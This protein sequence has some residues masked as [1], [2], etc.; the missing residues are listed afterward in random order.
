[1]PQTGLDSAVGALTTGLL[2]SSVAVAAIATRIRKMKK[3]SVK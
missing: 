1:M 2:L 3:V